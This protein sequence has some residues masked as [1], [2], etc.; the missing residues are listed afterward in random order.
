VGEHWITAALAAL[1]LALCCGMGLAAGLTGIGGGA[2]AVPMQQV[3]LRMP[4]R[5]AIAN[6]ACTIVFSAIIGSIYKNVTLPFVHHIA[7]WESVL[8]A[9]TLIPAAFIGSWIGARLTHRLPRQPVRIIFILL[10]VASVWV[11]WTGRK[12]PA[13]AAS[14]SNP[15]TLTAPEST[16]QRE[17]TTQPESTTRPSDFP[18]Q[19]PTTGP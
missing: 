14:P 17:S 15:T 16:T 8:I 1:S 10:L 18:A 12:S 19:H 4:L 3:F 9:L 13:S 11:M 6:S 7:V 2:L 5:K